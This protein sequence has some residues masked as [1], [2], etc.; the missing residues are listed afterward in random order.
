MPGK[1]PH[2]LVLQ[3]N[4]EKYLVLA[5]GR[6]SYEGGAPRQWNAIHLPDQE[7][8]AAEELT[9]REDYFSEGAGFTFE[10]IEG[11][12]ERAHR[13]DATA[14]GKV[15]TWPLF[16]SGEETEAGDYRGWQLFH[17]GLEYVMRGRYISK[18]PLDQLQIGV[19]LAKSG[20]DK[21][22][23][24]GKVVA[25]RPVSVAG[26]VAIPVLDTATGLCD[27]FKL[28][29]ALGTPDTY[30]TPDVALKARCFTVWNEK[31]VMAEVGNTIRLCDTASD[32]E[33]EAQWAPD[34][35]GDG[36][37][38]AP[39]GA[40]INDLVVFG[41]YLIALTDLGPYYCDEDLRPTPG[42]PELAGERD[43]YNGIGGAVSNN[44]VV[45]PSRGGFVRWVPDGPWARVGPEMEG[46]LEGDLT[47]GWGRVAGVANYGGLMFVVSNGANGV[48]TLWS[49]QPPRSKRVPYSIQCHQ[50][51][52]GV[53][54]EDVAVV[55]ASAQPLQGYAFGTLSDDDAAG[56]IAWTNPENAELND[57]SSATALEGTTHYLKGVNPNPALP[58]D[59]TLLGVE[60]I[61]RRSVGAAS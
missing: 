23:G 2:E 45:F 26:K 47:P 6:G 12:Y 58:A 52:E 16:T 28:I 19:E 29:T 18:F 8:P 40:Q 36:Y 46:A 15:G 41:P 27:T 44:A 13:V 1:E 38:M 59:A 33:D 55:L 53:Q 39:E 51:E 57:G 30:G 3:L 54:Y 21:D 31:L 10:G 7:A 35:N 50:Q 42:I 17:E 9:I 11:T 61:V 48:A 49:F 34:I 56:S 20:S 4:G 14:P 43:D 5:P 60:L 32:F 22:L 25:G 37:R 24:S